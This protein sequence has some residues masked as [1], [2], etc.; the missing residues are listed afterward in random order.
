MNPIIGAGDLPVTIGYNG[1]GGA[2]GVMDKI[3]PHLKYNLDTKKLPS[4]FTCFI[5][6]VTITNTATGESRM[7][8]VPLQAK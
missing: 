5:L 6:Q 8:T 1:V 2:G 3:G 7:E 4:S